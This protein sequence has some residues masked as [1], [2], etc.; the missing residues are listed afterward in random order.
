[1]NCFEKG[2]GRLAEAS[3]ALGAVTAV[4]PVVTTG[5]G[6]RNVRVNG[7]VPGVGGVTFKYEGGE[8]AYA[9]VPL[10]TPPTVVE[11]ALRAETDRQVQL[12]RIGA[13]NG[14]Q[15]PQNVGFADEGASI[16]LSFSGSGMPDLDAFNG[17]SN[18]KLV[19]G[20][21]P[22]TNHPLVKPTVNGAK[23]L[24]ACSSGANANHARDKAGDRLERDAFDQACSAVSFQGGKR[25]KVFKN[26]CAVS[27]EPVASAAVSIGDHGARACVAGVP[28]VQN[29]GGA[30]K[31]EVDPLADVYRCEGITKAAVLACVSS[32][33]REA[34]R[35]AAIHA[36]LDA[37]EKCADDRMKG[38]CGATRN[39]WFS[40]LRERANK[41]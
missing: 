15:V 8:T 2:M 23:V 13:A 3:L 14:D 9:R 37:A 29:A 10:G 28:R 35:G 6:V 11:N 26:N 17:Q 41:R 20:D 31:P 22:Q 1:M 30:L 33:G 34:P 27:V 4:A 39:A 25:Q 40:K 7:E 5:C 16:E 38:D 12:W 18:P 21:V 24:K 19:G 32:A 36:V